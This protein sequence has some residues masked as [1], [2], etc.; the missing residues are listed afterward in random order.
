MI[1]TRIERVRSEN[2]KFQTWY[3]N[4]SI[5]ENEERESENLNTYKHSNPN[6]RQIK[7]I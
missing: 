2:I 4:S 6:S 5:I 7:A 3:I 1:I